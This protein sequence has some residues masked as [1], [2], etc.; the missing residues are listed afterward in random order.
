MNCTGEQLVNRIP[1]CSLLTNKLGLL[2]S[3]QR[4]ERVVSSTAT[5][6]FNT[7]VKPLDFIPLTYHIDN[8]AER[9]AFFEEFQ[10]ECIHSFLKD[11]WTEN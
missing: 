9:Q 5:V 3:L 10:S 7:N 4:Y 2:N 6:E 11:I 1:N 8:H